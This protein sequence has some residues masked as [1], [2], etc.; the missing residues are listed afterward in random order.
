MTPDTRDDE[1][2]WD[3]SGLVDPAVADLEARLAPLRF[4]PASHPIALPRARRWRLRAIAAAAA[5]A[6]SLLLVTGFWYYEWRFEW[7]PNRAWPVTVAPAAPGAAPTAASLAVGESLQAIAP[8]SASRI[9]IARVGTIDASAGT[10]LTVSST[11]ARH[12]VR[13]ERGTVD[14]RLWAPPGVFALH[15]PAGDVID[16]G[17]VFQLAVDGD[18]TRLT[19]RTGWVQLSNHFG[20]SL[21]PAGASSTMRP[22]RRPLVPVYDD[23]AAAFA[24][25][26]RAFESGDT[27]GTALS[28]IVT[29]ARRRDVLTLLLLAARES[30]SDRATL[31]ARAAVLAP[32]PATAD[33]AAVSSGDNDALW[34]WIDDGLTLPPVKGWWRNWRDALPRLL[35]R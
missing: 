20:E 3:R 30:G 31:V 15:T 10:D 27:S 24:A 25:A 13:M 5:I 7:A 16:L 9:D 22:D 17:C 32:P 19:V 1:Y 2:L 28:S 21:V 34:R 18:T 33:L 26:V 12:R 23:A 29:T 14:V 35:A 8:A 4:D 6:A 11:G